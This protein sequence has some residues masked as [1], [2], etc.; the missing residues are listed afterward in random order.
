MRMMNFAMTPSYFPRPLEE[1][2][3]SENDVHREHPSRSYSRQCFTV[4]MIGKMRTALTKSNAQQS[5]HLSHS[6]GFPDSQSMSSCKTHRHAA[7][8]DHATKDVE[9]E[10]E[11]HLVQHTEVAVITPNTI[12]LTIGDQCPLTVPAGGINACSSTPAL[13]AAS[14]DPV[15]SSE[16]AWI[17]ISLMKEKGYSRIIQEEKSPVNLS[18]DEACSFD[19]ATNLALCQKV[20]D[21]IMFS[22][23]LDEASSEYFVNSYVNEKRWGSTDMKPVDRYA[24]ISAHKWSQQKFFNMSPL[25]LPSCGSSSEEDVSLAYAEHS[26]ESSLGSSMLLLA[27]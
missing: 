25:M 3:Q 10:I 27:P 9:E 19:V 14:T 8:E 18:A 24:K 21:H 4:K 12:P 22:H 6:I 17:K 15:L 16:S 2:R 26:F 11:S 1:L 23:L 7:T 5:V 13:L 20:R